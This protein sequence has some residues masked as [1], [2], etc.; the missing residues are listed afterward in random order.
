MKRHF[1][2]DCSIKDLELIDLKLFALLSQLVIFCDQEQIPCRVT[3]L[4]RPEYDGIS[5]SRTHQ[6]GRAADIAII[7]MKLRQR[8]KVKQF[9]TNYDREHDVGAIVNGK[10]R[11]LHAQDHG[12]GP[13]YHLQVRP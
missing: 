5:K 11:L 8:N 12:T 10:S 6:E 2:V 13:H 9:L 3:S 1:Q 7:N 4:I